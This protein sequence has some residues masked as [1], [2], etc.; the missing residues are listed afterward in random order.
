MDEG[1]GYVSFKDFTN[2]IVE[3]TSPADSQL[4]RLIRMPF[5]NTNI[6]SIIQDESGS[7]SNSGNLSQEELQQSI[8]YLDDLPPYMVN[9]LESQQ[10]QKPLFPGLSLEDQ[11]HWL[12]YE[13]AIQGPNAFI[14]EYFSFELNLKNLLAALNCRKLGKSMEGAI[15]TRN[16]AAQAILKSTAADFSLSGILP[17]ADRVINLP[18]GNLTEREKQ[19]DILRWEI[20]EDLTTFSYFGIDTILAFCI[21]LSIAERWSQLQPK[22]GA[23]LFVKLAG[24]LT[25]TFK[26]SSDYAAIGGK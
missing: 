21:R 5:D 1:K 12:F 16:E 7:F 22:E 26:E 17:W 15:I 25:R 14:S 20:M 24:D 9:F 3:Q 10:Q 19:L 11:L 8:K 6:I 23:R 13:W 4:V 2:D 18:L